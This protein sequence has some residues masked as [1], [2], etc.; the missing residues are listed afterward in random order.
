MNIEKLE[1]GRVISK[2]CGQDNN[3]VGYTGVDPVLFTI[4]YVV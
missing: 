3:L 4:L 2:K 1:L